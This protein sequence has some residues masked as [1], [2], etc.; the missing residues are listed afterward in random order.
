MLKAAVFGAGLAAL[1]AGWNGFTETAA[2]Q[3]VYSQAY[4][5]TTLAG[6]SSIGSA[7]EVGNG[8]RFDNPFGIAVD[9]SGNLF[10]ADTGT[11]P[12]G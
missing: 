6:S 2:G 7:D 12:S 10:V 8:A 4:T 1:V 3:S 5:F 11:I 9:S